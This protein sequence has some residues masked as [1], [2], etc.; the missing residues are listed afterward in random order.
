MPRDCA[1]RGAAPGLV[2]IRHSWAIA[3]HPDLADFALAPVTDNLQRCGR[4]RLTGAIPDHAES[5][6]L[7]ARTALEAG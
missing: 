1:R 3:P 7:L 2:V 6:L 4:R 5:R